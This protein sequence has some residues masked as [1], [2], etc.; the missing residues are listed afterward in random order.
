MATKPKLNIVKPVLGYGKVSDTDFL[1]RLNKIHT[2]TFGNPAYPTPPVDEPT[3]K[4]GIDAYAAAITAAIDGSKKDL[5]DR[6]KKRAEVTLMMRLVGHYVEGACKGDM[7]TFLTS[8]FEAISSTRTPPGPLEIPSI[9]KV[10]PGSTGQLLATVRP[11]AKAK[12]YEI[13]SAPL[14]AGQTAGAP[15][16][17]ATWTLTAATGTKPPIPINNLTPGTAYALQVRALGKLGYTDW[18]DTVNRICI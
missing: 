16:A 2:G 14:P 1:A 10:D 15:P 6:Q 18:S 12:S 11:V 4:A 8:G 9:T 7:T 3:F 17:N 5:A 13:R